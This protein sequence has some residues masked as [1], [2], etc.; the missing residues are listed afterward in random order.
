MCCCPREERHDFASDRGESWI[1]QEEE[2]RPAPARR[3]RRRRCRLS[4]LVERL[5]HEARRLK[6]EG[7][8][9]AAERASSRVRAI[10][11]VGVRSTA[12]QHTRE[13]RTKPRTEESRQQSYKL[14]HQAAWSA[15]GGRSGR[16]WP[17]P[18]TSKGAS[19]EGGT[20]EFK[21]GSWYPLCRNTL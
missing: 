21:D 12:R 18:E 4:G 15:R 3:R 13:A 1:G 8:P 5:D 9:R 16:R 2:G 11:V 7:L 19:R 10:R 6:A 17:G 14:A 20:S